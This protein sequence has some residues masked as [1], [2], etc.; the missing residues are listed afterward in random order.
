MR[1]FEI[2]YMFLKY[3]E[4]PLYQ[5]V[6]HVLRKLIRKGK[7]SCMILDVGGRRSNYT[8]GLPAKVWIT[9]IPRETELQNKLDL[10]ANESIIKTTIARRS[11][12]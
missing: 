12:Y 2:L 4:H 9:D 3:F 1:R 10:G 11:K 6:H 5:R 7:G 8:V